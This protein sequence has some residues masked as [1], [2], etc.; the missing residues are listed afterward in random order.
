MRTNDRRLIL[1]LN[2]ARHAQMQHLDSECRQL[3]GISA[4][5]LTALFYLKRHPNCL[6]KDLAAGLLLDT[7]AISGLIKR[8]EKLQLV[9]RATDN[10][11]RRAHRLSVTAFGAQCIERGVPLLKQ[12]NQTIENNF[13]EQE[14]AVVHR[15]LNH[16]IDHYNS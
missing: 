11:D 4:V 3:M 7:S 10:T 14:L 15:Y 12:H 6:M 13:S 5:Q 8:M 16:L 2:Q 1:L 9:E